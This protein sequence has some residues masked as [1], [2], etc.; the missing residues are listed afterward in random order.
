MAWEVQGARRIEK[1]AGFKGVC[2]EQIGSGGSVQRKVAA[3]LA[4]GASTLFLV[5]SHS[6]CLPMCVPALWH[7]TPRSRSH[8]TLDT[9]SKPAGAV[10]VTGNLYTRDRQRTFMFLHTAGIV[11]GPSMGLILRFSWQDCFSK[12]NVIVRGILRKDFLNVR[13]EGFT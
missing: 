8:S 3:C 11:G 5:R 1:R 13:E 2:Y 4:S 12:R 9:C 6:K 10:G 7:S